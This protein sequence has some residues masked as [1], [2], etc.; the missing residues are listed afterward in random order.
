M[1]DID[2]NDWPQAY[3][4]MDAAPYWEALAEDRLTFQRCQDCAD[5][6]WPAHSHC[7]ECGSRAL[8]WE[9]S[10]GRGRVYSWSTVYRG[11]T[12]VWESIAPYTVGFVEMV[13][14]YFLFTQI[15]GDPEDIAVGDEVNVRYVQRGE[16][17]LPVFAR[18]AA[19]SE[20]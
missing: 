14:G 4:M 16:Q 20:Q 2:P 7:P 5:V 9:E 17:R 6:V 1:T 11:P 8:A 10:S 19:E 18:A 12:P 3:R 13:E 15:E